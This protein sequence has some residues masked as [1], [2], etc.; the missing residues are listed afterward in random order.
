MPIAEAILKEFPEL[1]DSQREAVSHTDGPLLVIAGPG[2][3]KTLVLVVRALNILLQGLAQPNEILLCTFTEKAAFE[4]RD[5]LSLAA[6]KLAYPGDLSEL[7]IGTI[8]GICNDF[9]L[10]YRHR[11]PAGKQL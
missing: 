9:L 4:M 5:R 2:S 3:G 7:I 10:R 11:T 6:K 8:H 1:N